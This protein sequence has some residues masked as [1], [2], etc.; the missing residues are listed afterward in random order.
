MTPVLLAIDRQTAR[1]EASLDLIFEARARAIAEHGVGAGAQR[2][3]FADDVDGLAQ[4][5]GRAERAEVAAAVLDDLA[6]DGDTRPR[7]IGDL[8]A[9]VGFIVFEADVYPCV[10]MHY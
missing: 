7:V 1:P 2:K 5:V 4:T 6:G 9:Q 10:V 8:G 3:H